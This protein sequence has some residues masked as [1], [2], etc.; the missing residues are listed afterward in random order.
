MEEGGAA[1]KTGPGER[2]GGGFQ[3]GKKEIARGNCVSSLDEK[4]K[5]VLPANAASDNQAGARKGAEF[6]PGREGN[7][8][9]LQGKDRDGGKVAATRGVLNYCSGA[10]GRCVR[11]V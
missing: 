1:E 3:G 7:A 6:H 2:G 4:E 5:N 11:W 8:F 10:E 9:Q